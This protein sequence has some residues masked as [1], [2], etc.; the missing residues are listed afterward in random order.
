MPFIDIII[1]THNR[2]TLLKRAIDSVLNQ[3]FSDFHLIVVDDGSTDHT[4]EILG[5][6]QQHSQV[7]LLEKLNSGVSSARNFGVAHSSASW[8]AFLDSDDE[9]LPLKLQKAVDFI[10]VHPSIEFI[11][12]DETWIRNGVRVNPP[13]KYKKDQENLF[14]RSLEFCIISPS[15]SL[16]TRAL[17]DKYGPFNESYPVCEDYDLW[18]KIL[19]FDNIGYLPDQLTKKYGGHEDQLSTRYVA[20]DYWRFCSL[21]ELYSDPRLTSIQREQIRTA[22]IVK[23]DFLKKGLTKYP[24]PGRLE[25]IN[26]K[27]SNLLK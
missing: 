14:E 10:K 22:L 12:T 21:C 27:L 23:A 19:A 16:M 26:F 25:E 2:A 18:N 3:S 13:L 6:Y 17:F 11:H 24:D 1:P 20:M 5:E 4:Q 7:T 15:T 9:W 8:I